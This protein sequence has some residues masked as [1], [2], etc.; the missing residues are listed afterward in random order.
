MQLLWLTMCSLFIVHILYA[1][2]DLFSIL[3]WVYAFFCFV[4]PHSIDFL[5]LFLPL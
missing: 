5:C 3:S 1:A 2:A 4:L